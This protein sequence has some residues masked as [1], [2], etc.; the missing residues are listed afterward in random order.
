MNVRE[1]YYYHE[2]L[3]LVR[4]NET[5][6]FNFEN[7]KLMWNMNNIKI[8]NKYEINYLYLSIQVSY[9]LRFQTIKKKN[10]IVNVRHW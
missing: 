2:L 5:H 7:Q 3:L 8:K 1:I 9:L 10:N 6:N 4:F